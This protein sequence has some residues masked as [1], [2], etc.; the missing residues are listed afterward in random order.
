MVTERNVILMLNLASTLMLGGIVWYAHAAQRR[1]PR[2]RWWKWIA[3]GFALGSVRS[4]I[5][6]FMAISIIPRSPWEVVNCLTLNVVSIV[7]FFSI[8][9]AAQQAQ[10]SSAALDLLDRTNLYELER[11]AGAIDAR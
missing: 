7:L 2:E 1:I 8:R 6:F 3:L 10:N 9:A 11:R 4:W 5:A